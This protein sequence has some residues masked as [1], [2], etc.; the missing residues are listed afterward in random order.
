MP[1]SRLSAPTCGNPT[2][3]SSK[4]SSRRR[5]TFSIASTL[6][7]NS[8]KPST[9]CAERKS[10]RCGKKAMSP[11]S[12]MLATA[13]SSAWRISAIP[14]STS[15]PTFTR[16]DLR[17]NRAYFLKEAFD[18]FWKYNSP[19]WAR[20]FLRK[21]CT[22]TM[23]SRLDPMKKFVRTLRKHEELLMNYFKAGKRYNSGIVEGLN[24]R[25][26]L[27]HEKSLRLPQLRR[28]QNRPISPTWRNSQSPSPPTNSAE[29]PNFIHP[30]TF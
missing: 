19:Q 24:L 25:V 3:R 28:P 2:S 22:R 1:E 29:E 27:N 5:S 14:N 8:V 17:T 7:E 23:R 9:K 13:F 15:S 21:W 12:K 26:N 18:G 10:N 30:R 16:Y 6:P 4:R 20:W 11:F